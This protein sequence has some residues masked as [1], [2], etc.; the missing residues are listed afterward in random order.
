MGFGLKAIGPGLNL[1]ISE[2]PTTHKIRTF[3]LM[4]KKKDSDPIHALFIADLNIA[5]FLRSSHDQLFQHKSDLT[6]IDS[7]TQ[8]MDGVLKLRAKIA[9]IFPGQEV[10]VLFRPALVQAFRLYLGSGGRSELSVDNLM[11]LQ[12]SIIL[13]RLSGDY[14]SACDLFELH[15]EGFTR[16]YPRILAF[17]ATTNTVSWEKMRKQ[18]EEVLEE[19]F[20]E[21][22]D[23]M[24]IAK[25]EFYRDSRL[26]NE[27][28]IIAMLLVEKNGTKLDIPDGV[29]FERECERLLEEAG[30]IVERTSVSGDFGIDL[31][32][33]KHGLTYAIQCKYY[34]IPVGV[35]AIQEA[36]AGRLHYMADCAVV[37]AHSGFTSQA[38]RLAESNSVL[39]IGASQLA[40]LQDLARA[41]L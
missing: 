39:L 40:E 26:A 18:T 34:S 2:S 17:N 38:R 22:Y 31:V 32:A 37:V 9:T 21:R 16:A 25:T 28:L 13:M 14:I 6:N 20:R 5:Q 24:A 4:K 23:E 29:G 36:A 10:V 33:R 41:L 35:S 30:Y 1:E 27:A 11:F 3:P 7:L 15:K 12:L 19:A 8:D